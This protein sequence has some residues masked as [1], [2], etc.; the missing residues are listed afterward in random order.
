LLVVVVRHQV[1]QCPPH[2][3]FSLSCQHFLGRY[4]LRAHTAGSSTQLLLEN[5][6]CRKLIVQI[7]LLDVLFWM[8]DVLFGCFTCDIGGWRCSWSMYRFKTKQCFGCLPLTEI[9]SHLDNGTI[10]EICTTEYAFRVSANPPL[11]STVLDSLSFMCWF[12]PICVLECKK[13]GGRWQRGRTT[14]SYRRTFLQHFH[15]A[16]VLARIN[17]SL[18]N[19]HFIR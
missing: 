18:K 16:T 4:T 1:S 11:L 5:V 6:E 12:A 19:V 3:A 13:V 15:M 2:V 17:G 8:L 14:Q 9:Y 7:C 10:G